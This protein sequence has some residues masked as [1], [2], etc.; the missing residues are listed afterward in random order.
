AVKVT[1]LV[2]WEDRGGD[3]EVELSTILT[4]WQ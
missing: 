4:N 2:S 3:Y 1:A